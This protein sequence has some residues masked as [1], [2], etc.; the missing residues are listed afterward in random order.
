MGAKVVPVS[1]TR[2]WSAKQQRALEILIRPET[3][4]RGTLYAELRDASATVGSNNSL[5][6]VY[7]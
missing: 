6:S 1:I 4:P 3:T 7:R 5:G 2:K